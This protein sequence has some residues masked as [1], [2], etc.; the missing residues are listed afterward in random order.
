[1]LG[2]HLFVEAARRAYA[3]RR[4]VGADPDALEPDGGKALLARL[5]GSEHL[6]TRKPPVDRDHATPSA[7]LAPDGGDPQAAGAAG[8]AAGAHESPET[9]HFSVV[10]AQGN[11]VSCTYTQSASFGSKVMIPGTGVL[12]GNA[13]GGFSPSGP[14]RLAPGR[15]MASSMTP[16]I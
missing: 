1:G 16:A 7:A 5:L 9:T 8:V 13:M 2:L 15:R 11:A 4:L 12:L 10:D 14:N 3:E 6:G